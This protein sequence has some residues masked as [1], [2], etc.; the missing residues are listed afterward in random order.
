MPEGVSNDQNLI[1]LPSGK[2]FNRKT[3]SKYSDNEI[4]AT[5][6][7][8]FNIAHIL[9]TLKLNTVYHY[10]IK[11]FIKNNNLSTDHFKII[12]N[13]TETNDKTIRSFTTFKRNLLK[14]GKLINKCAICKIEAIWNNKPLTLHLD[15]INGDNN[16]NNLENLRLLCPNCHSQTDTYTGRN[17]KKNTEKDG[18]LVNEIIKKPI[19]KEIY[20]IKEPIIKEK[21]VSNRTKNKCLSCS[22]LIRNENSSGKCRVCY[23]KNL[24]NITRPSYRELIEEVNK[25]GVNPTS[26]KY[27]VANGTIKKWI[28]YYEKYG[29]ETPLTKV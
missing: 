23:N 17:C 24:R 4:K 19:K 13:H 14:E 26:R 2:Q 10:K 21:K 25:N 5:V 12:Y 18:S 27:N 3:F 20:T 15:H 22:N 28:K 16:N 7:E 29:D 9:K 6:S 1:V 11:E 8:C